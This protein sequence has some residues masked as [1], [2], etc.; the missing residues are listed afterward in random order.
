LEIK[1]A[2]KNH[3]NNFLKSLL[4]SLPNVMK[5]YGGKIVFYPL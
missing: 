1:K 4:N 3:F 5:K 2:H